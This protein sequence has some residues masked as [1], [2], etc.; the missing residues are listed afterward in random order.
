MSKQVVD[1]LLLWLSS[2]HYQRATALS[3][4]CSASL[5]S[6]GM[7]NLFY[8]APIL[9]FLISSLVC[10]QMPP[11]IHVCF[12]QDACYRQL[13]TH[14]KFRS[15]L[16]IPELWLR[17]R[18]YTSN[19]KSEVLRVLLLCMHARTPN[20]CISVHGALIFKLTFSGNTVTF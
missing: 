17:L 18:N 3:Q 19:V 11:H 7:I 2:R 6:L 13:K 14:W 20:A 12:V 5:I 10:P 1:A 8:F 15:H 4:I 9:N 16:V